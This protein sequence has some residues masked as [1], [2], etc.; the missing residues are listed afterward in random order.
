MP[1]NLDETESLQSE[2][3]KEWI[4]DVRGERLH[5]IAEGTSSAPRMGNSSAASFPIETSF[6]GPIAA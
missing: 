5:G 6:R 1:K 3:R 2:K 4:R